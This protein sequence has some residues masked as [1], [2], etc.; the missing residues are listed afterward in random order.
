MRLAQRV[1]HERQVTSNARGL[2]C[3]V[4]R[5]SAVADDRVHRIGGGHANED[6][7]QQE[8]PHRCLGRANDADVGTFFRRL[9]APGRRKMPT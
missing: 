1:E 3:R 2:V 9:G 4:D 7:E 5:H 8:D 6:D